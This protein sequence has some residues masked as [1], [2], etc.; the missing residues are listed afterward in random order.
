[1]TGAHKDDIEARVEI[2]IR[3]LKDSQVSV[4]WNAARD[5]ARLGPDAAAA[6]PALAET[7]RLADATSVLWARYAIAKITGNL[8]KHLPVFIEALTDWRVF[9]GMAAAAIA[10]FGAEAK[11]AV[12]ALIAALSDPHP[13]NRWSAVGALAN[14]GQEAREAVPALIT[15][16]DD[17]DEK[18]RWYAAWAL[19]EIG[20]DARS[21][22][23]ALMTA[24]DDSDEDVRGYA[25]RALGRIQP[26]GRAA[27]PQLQTLLTE[28]NGAIREEVAAALAL[29][30]SG[31]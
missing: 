6:L 8:P 27:I 22:V 14:I 23:P 11:E 29:L 5:L 28:A 20:P 21:A 19:S 3:A 17:A 9:P 10:G 7:L 1:M 15:A 2:L 13:D 26:E 18:M 31:K 25:A 16:L 4:C 12:P 30:E 24:L